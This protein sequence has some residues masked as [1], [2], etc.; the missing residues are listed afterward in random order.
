[1]AAK[2][3]PQLPPRWAEVMARVEQALN[4]AIE[5]ADRRAQA[6][7]PLPATS[8]DL[9]EGLARFRERLRGLMECASQAEQAVA[10]AD[11]DLAA[12]EEAL[13]TWFQAAE[14]ARRRL[15][16]WAGRA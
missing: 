14:G 5:A 2:A 7:Q 3:D 15:A 4:G 16:D 6:L 13:R 12:G 10:S 9:T 8:L 11:A 1:M